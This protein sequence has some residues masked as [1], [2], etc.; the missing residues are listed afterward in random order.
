[1]KARYGILRMAFGAMCVAGLPA[2]ASAATAELFTIEDAGQPRMFAVAL[3]ELSLSS[4]AAKRVITPIAPVADRA[5]LKA[6]AAA[7]KR[8]PSQEVE[9][10]LYETRRGARVGSPRILTREVLVRAGSAEAV[11]R[12]AQATGA[13]GVKASGV[14]GLWLLE[15]ADAIGALELAADLRKQPGITGAEPLL[16]RLQ[17]KKWVPNDPYFNIKQWHLRNTGQSNGVAGT[18]VRITNV[19]DTYRGT[20]LYIAIIDDG[21]QT[22]HLDLLGNCATTIDW[23]INY[24]DNNPTPD[25]PDDN[26]GTACAGVAAAVGNNSRGVCGAAPQ[27]RLVGLRLISAAAT[28]ADEEK[29]INWSNQVIQVKNNSWGPSDDG[30]TVEGPGTLMATALANACTTGRGGRG[31]VIVWAGGNGL[32]A[33]DDSNF[34]GY[35]NSIYTLAVGA[36]GNTSTQSWYSEPGANLMVCAPS[37]GDNLSGVE[38]GIWTTDRSGTN[39]YNTGST[40]GE[41]P[42]GDY[43]STF[44][45]TSSA[46][47]LVSGVIALILQSNPNLGWRDVQE[48]LM[49][50]ATKN[51]AS[52][53]GW[54]T[55]A[56][57][58]PFNH[59]YGAGM[60][61]ASGA[62]AMA[63]GWVNLSPQS[64]LISNKPS[65]S[66]NIPDFGAGAITQTFNMAN[67]TMR[68]EHVQV[69]VSATHTWRGDLGFKLISPGGTT[70]VISRV[71][72]S[73]NGTNYVAWPF[74]SV[75]NWGEN[76]TGTW[77][78]RV[79]DL[80]AGDTGR[81]TALKLVFYGTVKP[82]Q[83][84]GPSPAHLATGV[85]TNATLS[86]TAATNA[87]GYRVNFGTASPPPFV[88]NQ[89]TNTFSTNLAQGTTYY[90]RID[91]TNA[92]GTTTGDVWQFTTGV[93]PALSIDPSST[94]FTDAEWSGRTIAVAANV[95]WTAVSN[96]PWIAVTAGSSGTTNGTVTYG[97]ATNAGA[98]VRT[99]A[100]I[101][102][103]GGISRTCTVTQAGPIGPPAVLDDVDFG[104]LSNQFGFNLNWI[105][106]RTVVVDACT[107]LAAPAPV[108]T[109]LQT[110]LLTGTPVYFYDPLWSNH[111]GRFYRLREE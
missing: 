28:D 51:A 32:A 55:N 58:F 80:G 93:T 18:D 65:L 14:E 64:I 29:A 47:P 8:D 20:N 35:A 75:R 61:N 103:G 17:T 12:A 34:D 3:D 52:D 63:S 100:V 72:R 21:L 81:L 86:W 94:N 38:V 48:I 5:E 13:S 97:V 109:P 108:W 30:W 60:V 39:G 22:S 57:G 110:N 37:S 45:G 106:G 19:W 95:A 33:G 49:R 36:V 107:N 96:V 15:G 50:S 79:E 92:A 70:S 4:P 98:G 104:M 9:L 7:K 74:M 23:D 16:A 6:V 56:A 83:A 73:D 62:V 46:A 101:V 105:S 69:V 53:A 68:V 10:V 43:T 31:V 91:P 99:G 11:D 44:G 26:H 24:N 84:S 85:A 78:V 111:L 77:R 67:A 66:V 90:W 42:D 54:R 71:N 82:G 25:L 59:K 102:A 87:T 2:A 76:L 27:A 40:A 89:T 88:R 41:P 1:M